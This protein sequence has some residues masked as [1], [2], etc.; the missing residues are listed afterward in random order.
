MHASAHSIPR[1]FPR[2]AQLQAYDSAEYSNTPRS[3]RLFSA[4]AFRA[5]QYL[6]ASGLNLDD[7]EHLHLVA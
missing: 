4:Q 7:L 6:M 5:R 2:L 3:V 1:G